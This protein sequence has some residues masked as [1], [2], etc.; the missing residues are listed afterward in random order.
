M[1]DRIR[2]Q[3]DERFKW[4]V[5]D[6]IESDEAWQQ[7]FEEVEAKIPAVA[8]CQGT[9]GTKEGFAAYCRADEDLGILLG[10]VYLYA[11]MQKDADGTNT[12]YVGM[13][14]NVMGLLV[15]VSQA[16]AY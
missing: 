12:K 15:R 14:G 7:A 5:S 4:K 16:S 11:H 8:A 6:I 3:I 1:A 10:K 9:L 13:M 2:E